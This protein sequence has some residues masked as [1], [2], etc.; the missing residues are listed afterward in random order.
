M[1]AGLNCL[2]PLPNRL[3]EKNMQ[4]KKKSFVYSVLIL[5]ATLVIGLLVVEVALRLKNSSMTNYDIE[6]WRYARQ[7]KKPSEDPALGHEHR[8]NVDAVLQSVDIRINNMGL[9][10]E[11]VTDQE[12][13]RRI[14]FLGSS[15][16]FGWG[17]DEADTMTQLLEKKLKEKGRDVRVY[18][19][20]IGN[21]NTV[22][23]VHR[24]FKN[25]ES[26][27]PTDIVVNYFI[28]DAE[29]LSAGGGNFL[30]RNSQLA[31]TIWGV[32]NKLMHGRG[33]EGLEEHYRKVY[34]DDS[35]GYVQM[36]RSLEELA[37]YA[38]DNKVNLYLLMTPDVHQL[39]D[40]PF[41]FV[42]EK[43][44]RVAGDLGYVL[45]DTIDEFSKLSPEE[46]W[47]MPGDPHP[48]KLGHEIMAEA[49]YRELAAQ[50][51]DR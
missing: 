20:G 7:L 42:H 41:M 16:T 32:V 35:P 26:I 11:D 43:V 8:K 33:M 30:L 1:V 2:C 50:D 31:V 22:R 51:L 6:M 36:V 45:I 12:P 34:Q 19:A 39:T 10:G 23:Y 18:N 27:K 21:Y 14:L 24:F 13:E 3:G 47:A 29:Q 48:N 9:R 49:I 38:R 40:Y 4:S 15:I 46:L 25:L 5:V 37:G 17:V 28:N 44:G